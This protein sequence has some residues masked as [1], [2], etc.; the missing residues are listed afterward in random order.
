MAL[1]LWPLYSTPDNPLVSSHSPCEAW[2][3][4]KGMLWALLLVPLLRRIPDEQTETG[5]RLLV[6]GLVTGL[7][8]LCCVVVWERHVFV[9][10]GDFQNVFRVTGSFSSMATGGAYIEA[11][12]AFVFPVLAVWVLQQKAWSGKLAGVFLA[13][14]ASYAMMVTFSRGGYAALVTGFTVVGVAVLRW[15]T[16]SLSRRALVLAGVLVA[17]VVVALPVLKG[18]FAKARLSQ[19]AEDLHTRLAHWGRALDIMDHGFLTALGGM[20][21]GRY[22][23]QYLYYADVAN[24]PGNYSLL[25]ENDETFVRLG[26]GEPVYLDQL[27]EVEPG[28]T[29]QLSARMRSPFGK[30]ELKVIICEKALLTSFDCVAEVF[31]SSKEDMDG[32][33]F[34]A[35]AD[36]DLARLGRGGNWPHRSVKLSLFNPGSGNPVDVEALSFKSAD[37]EESL[38]NGDFTAGMARWL[39]VSDQDLAWHIHQQEIEMYFAQGW[40]G[41]LAFALLLLALAERLWPALRA[42]D[43]YATAIS[44]AVVAF[45]TVGLLGST[46]DTARLSMLLYLGVLSGCVL[47]PA[48]RAR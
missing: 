10:L 8:L 38:A 35:T 11:Y 28:S 26:G 36:L 29:Y 18:D 15:R 37:G 7:A 32:D 25:S 31:A 39:F 9:G 6:R 42:G 16:V 33:W 4:G 22:P 23:V 5:Q 20:G 27:I 2:Y 30:S 21:F 40:L 45:L 44:G 13:A 19:S 3:V 12:I 17:A 1:G 41:L 43:P 47:L 46:M 14:L 48:T 34:T 24:Y